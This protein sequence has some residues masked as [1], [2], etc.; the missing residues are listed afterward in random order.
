MKEDIDHWHIVESQ[1][2]MKEVISK[3][4]SQDLDHRSVIIAGIKTTAEKMM[5]LF[6]LN[7]S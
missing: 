3:L 5:Q 1:F 6:H 4:L 7:D 2:Q